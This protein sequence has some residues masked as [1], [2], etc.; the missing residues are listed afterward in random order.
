MSDNFN[1]VLDGSPAEEETVTEETQEQQATTE[2]TEQTEA[3]DAEAA[4]AETATEAEAGEPTVLLAVFKSMRDDLKGQ[5]DQI[6][7]QLNPP[8][9]PEPVKA[10]DMFEQPE[11]YQ[12]FMADQFNQVKTSTKLE[13]SRFMAE[14]EFGAEAVQEVVEYFNQHPQLSHQFI[15]EASPFHAAKQYVDAQKTAKEIGSDPE[16]YKAKLEREIREKLEAEMAAKQAQEMA[17]KSAPS[18]ANTNGSGG[19]TDPGWSGPTDLN[20]L[21]GE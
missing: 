13:M 8:Q 5:L 19:Q 14:R 12:K 7:S 4:E 1:D 2:Q 15:S 17:G 9:Q 6:R 18:L 20:S 3:K 21:I 16:A 11:Q 10:P